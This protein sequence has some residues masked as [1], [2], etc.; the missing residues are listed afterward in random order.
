M[1]RAT[2][3]CIALVAGLALGLAPGA[4][5]QYGYEL[6]QQQQPEQGGAEPAAEVGANG[7]VFTGGLSFTPA[8]VTVPLGGI[9]RWTNTDFLVP[10]T[11]T[12]DHA[13]WDLGGDY[14]IPANIAPGNMGYGPGETVERPFEAGTH[15]Y[16][17]RVHPDTM[18]AVVAVAPELAVDRQQVR[19][20]RR[21]RSGRRR[22][23]TVVSVV[24]R[25]SVAEPAEGL[26]FDVQRRRAGSEEWIPF[27]DGTR[28][29]TASFRSGRSPVTWEVRARLRRADDA[30]AATDWSPV[31]QI[32]P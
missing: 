29:T 20:R 26:A 22:L 4:A 19:S 28:E 16:F 25:W 24:A 23:V 27:R 10:H 31:A 15:R 14:G 21:T 5:G 12:E 30:E 1:R 32:A 6:P 13:L 9:V 11:S 8:E 2:G 18:K 7:N 17:C 3:G